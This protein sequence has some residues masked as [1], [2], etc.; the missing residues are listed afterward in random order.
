M[1]DAEDDEVGYEM[2]MP[3]VVVKSVGGEL[4]DYAYVAGAE[5]GQLMGLLNH[6][7]PPFHEAYVHTVNVPQIDLAAMHHGYRME[8]EPWD[9]HPDEWTHIRLTRATDV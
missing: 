9:E 7:R 2:L 6:V 4:D 5:Y 8:S 1:P 3:L